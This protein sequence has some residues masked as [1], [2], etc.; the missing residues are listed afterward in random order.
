MNQLA[1]SQ[2]RC[3]GCPLTFYGEL[4]LDLKEM[5]VR[6]VIVRRIT[7]LKCEMYAGIITEDGTTALWSVLRW[8]EHT[9]RREAELHLAK[10]ERDEAAN[11]ADP[12][13]SPKPKTP[14]NKKVKK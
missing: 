1:S 2:N 13:P 9:A 11:N 4:P 10:M 14:K 12:L 7:R 6:R 3:P 8:G 5:P